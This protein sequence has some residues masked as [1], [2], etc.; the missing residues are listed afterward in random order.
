MEI[1]E[2]DSFFLPHAWKLPITR[3]FKSLQYAS[4]LK[5]W[6]KPMPKKVV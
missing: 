3:T 5:E 6:Q 1:E 2:N 4:I